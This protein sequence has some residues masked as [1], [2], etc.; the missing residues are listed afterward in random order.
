VKRNYAIPG[1]TLAALLVVAIVVVGTIGNGSTPSVND[2]PQT[3]ATPL[4]S[5]H[6][7]IGAGGE[8]AGQ[9]SSTA[10]GD[11]SVMISKLEKELAK[12]PSDTKTALA[13]ADAYL[14]TDQ[15]DKA[16][17]LYSDVVDREPGNLTARV[18]LALALHATGDDKKALAILEALIVSAPDNQAAHYNL[19]IV[20]FSQDKAAQAKQ[21]W[22]KAAAIDPTSRLGASAQN[23]VDMME[24][25]S[26]APTS[27]P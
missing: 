23:F 14:S 19:A 3:G 22:E 12:D 13:L 24:G 27:A 20:Y 8:A 25:R 15:P 1:L 5:G 2:G 4:P 11:A 6:P 21:E 7:S 16:L 10:T 18:Q 26:P 17:K 9:G